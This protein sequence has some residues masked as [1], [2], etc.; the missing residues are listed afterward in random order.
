MYSRGN[1]STESRH[2]TA[3]VHRLIIVGP[4]EVFTTKLDGVTWVG[5]P[6]EI[7][8][9]EDAVTNYHVRCR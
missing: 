1:L 5:W 7:G 8:K 6:A 4:P 9:V 3:R 2:I